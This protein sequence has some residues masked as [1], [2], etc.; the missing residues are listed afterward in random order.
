ME[1]HV[2]YLE[3]HLVEKLKEK[4]YT[5]LE[6]LNADIRKLVAALNAR[7]F[8]KENYSRMDAF[9][10]YDK[11]CMRPLPGGI[12]TVCDYKTVTKI[13][14]NYH[15]EY[16]NHYYSVVYTHCGKS[17]IIKATPSEIHICDQYN[18][19]ICKHKRSYKDFPKYITEDS[20]MRPEHLYYKEVNQ[21][22]GAYY[23]RWASV[24]GPNM[25][26]CIDRILKA[27]KHEEQPSLIAINLTPIAGNNRSIYIPESIYSL[28]NRLRSFVTT[29]S[30][31]PFLMSSS[32]I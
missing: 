5:S 12:Y 15:V 18:R 16:D 20:H 11:P 9:L 8:Q 25:S 17:A 21:K 1:N 27:A 14:D 6:S 30:I 4:V 31:L 3:T 7:H 13:P 19:L 32:I 10:K 24:F 2:R 29:Q 28:P 26:E 23:R 22:D